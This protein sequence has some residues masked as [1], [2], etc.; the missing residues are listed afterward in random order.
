MSSDFLISIS[1]LAGFA[2]VGYG[3]IWYSARQFDRKYGKR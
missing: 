2:V 3:W 1:M